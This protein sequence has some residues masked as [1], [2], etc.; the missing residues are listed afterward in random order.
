MSECELNTP[1]RATCDLKPLCKGLFSLL[2]PMTQ[3][4]C[5]H[6]GLL[7]DR[8]VWGLCGGAGMAASVTS[9]CVA[10]PPLVFYCLSDHTE[11]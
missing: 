6:S 11:T 5:Q 2:T 7:L 8:V 4:R 9:V 10:G 3:T 1:K